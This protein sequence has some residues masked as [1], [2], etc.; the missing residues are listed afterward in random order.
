I[1]LEQELGEIQRLVG[2]GITPSAERIKEYVQ[3][4]CLKGNPDMQKLVSCIADIL[5]LEE[6]RCWSTDATLK[7]ILVVLESVRSVQEL[8]AVFVGNQ[9]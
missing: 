6:E 7:D 2:A 4:S 9:F 1:N 5:R 3:V 8:K